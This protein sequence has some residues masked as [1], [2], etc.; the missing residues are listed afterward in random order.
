MLA[1][2]EFASCDRRAR[3]GMIA[4]TAPPRAMCDQW[5]VRPMRGFQDRFG[6]TLKSP[7]G[8]VGARCA[9]AIVAAAVGFLV[10][11]GHVA[12]TAASDARP[13]SA[14]G[15]TSEPPGSDAQ[16]TEPQCAYLG[17]D[18]FGDMQVEVAF[19]NPLG[20]V[21]ALEITY[22]LLDGTGIRFH[23]GSETFDFVAADESFR[24]QSDTVTNP[25]PD[26]DE[27]AV[28]CRVLAIEEGSSFR[29]GSAPSPSDT[30]TL[31]EVDDF[32]D[33]QI[34]MMVTSPLPDTAT[35]RAHY[36]LRGSDGQRFGTGS[37]SVEFVASG[38]TI[39]IPVDT[40]TDQPAWI[41]DS[42]IV[43]EILLIE[44]SSF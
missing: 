32:G 5:Y 17:V 4:T 7:I 26:L 38:E 9:S 39:R 30:C 24:A 18:D 13:T 19:T 44:E 14:G 43:C 27:V 10:A 11:S 28:A 36:A 23:T 15:S 25:P 20:A 8:G 6:Q 31:V 34:E 37:E 40:L 3:G 33:I 21:P 2:N 41:T 42:E 1:V 22:A 29:E 35:I 12:A 16:P